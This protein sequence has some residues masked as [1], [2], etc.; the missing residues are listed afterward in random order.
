MQ[1]KFKFQAQLDLASDV[2]KAQNKREI[3][4]EEIDEALFNDVKA[5]AYGP[6]QEVARQASGKHERT[7]S[8]E[9]IK[10]S[11]KEGLSE[12]ELETT[13]KTISKYFSKVMKDAIRR[14]MLDD[15]IRLDG[16]K[17]QRDSGHLDGDRLP[18][19]Y[20]RVSNL[21]KR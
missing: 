1:S 19:K 4:T 7:A 6:C 2:E 17:D 16:R 11:L 18:S 14:V 15:G 12:E 3:L 9:A 10:A 20:T 13:G 8:F 21:H 5:K